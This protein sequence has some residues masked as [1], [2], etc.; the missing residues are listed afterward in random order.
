MAI[1]EACTCVKR[2]GGAGKRQQVGEIQRPLH[3]LRQPV[4]RVTQRPVRD[5]EEGG[6]EDHEVVDVEV[7]ADQDRGQQQE[8]EAPRQRRWRPPR[9]AGGG[10]K[11]SGAQ[12]IDGQ[13]DGVPRQQQPPER[14]QRVHLVRLDVQERR[15]LADTPQPRP[16]V[17]HHAGADHQPGQAQLQHGP[18]HRTGH[19]APLASEQ[20]HAGGDEAEL[21]LEY[22]GADGEAGKKRPPLAQRQEGGRKARQRHRRVLPVRDQ[23]EERGRRRP[24]DGDRRTLRAQV[25]TGSPDQPAADAVEDS[26]GQRPQHEGPGVR[27]RRERRE[28][29]RHLRAVDR[30]VVGAARFR[31]QAGGDL[32]KRDTIVE[33]RRRAVPRD[34]AEGVEV[35]EVRPFDLACAIEQAGRPDVHRED[36]REARA[37][38]HGRSTNV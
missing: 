15:D 32:G 16:V 11:G 14:Q 12:P 34:P 8:R 18:G 4:R 25:G 1:T 26:R 7:R 10:D 29:Q 35:G 9:D 31:E 24:Q 28:E 3:R 20:E 36:Q 33:S 27:Q 23:V 2:R 19:D 6:R 5:D 17:H 22:Q 37:Q 30:Q 13:G 21:G 38:Q